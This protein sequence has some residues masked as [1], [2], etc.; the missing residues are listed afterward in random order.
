MVLEDRDELQR[1]IDLAKE[2][3]KSLTGMKGKIKDMFAAQ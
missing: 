2:E 1:G 3:I